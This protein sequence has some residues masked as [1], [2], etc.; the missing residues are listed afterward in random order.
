MRLIKEVVIVFLLF[1]SLAIAAE[2]VSIESA[3][4]VITNCGDLDCFKVNF[5]ECSPS[6]ITLKF[7]DEKT[8]E[9]EIKT[10]SSSGCEV[11][12]KFTKHPD[13]AWYNKKMSCVYDNS[14]EFEEAVTDMGKCSGD[15][16]ILFTTPEE[17]ETPVE[18][19]EEEE[20]ETPEE[21]EEPEEEETPAEE[22]VEEEK[23]EEPKKAETPTKKTQRKVISL[24]DGCMIG[25][26]CVKEGS[27]RSKEL[28]G[29][30]Y[31]CSSDLTVEPV[32]S[33]SESCSVDYECESYMCDEGLCNLVMESSNTP[34]IL[35]G[36]LIALVIILIIGAY[37][38]VKIGIGVKKIK[39]TEEKIDKGAQP[40][41]PLFSFKK[42]EPK[43]LSEQQKPYQYRADYDPLE[44]KMKEKFKK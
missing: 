29:Q 15:L 42:Q 24:C 9:Y 40:K 22:D 44:R 23:K 13:R 35:T 26:T 17:E 34:T 37:F 28:G 30:I 3:T 12:S 41:K 21:E 38:L 43:K 5:N 16:Y 14:I 10:I 33:I 4:E 36:V 20:E 2:D 8:Y 11:S 39:E 18:E 7:G 32:K 19:E 25:E 1:L 27:Q 6:I 31:Y